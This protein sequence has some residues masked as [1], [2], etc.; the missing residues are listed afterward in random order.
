MTETPREYKKRIDEKWEK[1][2]K[3]KDKLIQ[4][5]DSYEL[6]D[7]KF[8]EKTKQEILDNFVK[9]QKAEQESE[10]YTTIL[11][12][13]WK[14]DQKYV[15]LNIL[16]EELSSTK[17]DI[18]KV[19]K[20]IKESKLD[21]ADETTL[22]IQMAWVRKLKEKLATL[23]S[24]LEELQNEIKNREQE[25]KEIEETYGE[26]LEDSEA[27]PSC[28]E[29]EKS[30]DSQDSTLPAQWETKKNKPTLKNYQETTIKD[31]RKK[32]RT[33]WAI[34]KLLEDWTWIDD[35]LKEKIE[36]EI[37]DRFFE[38]YDE[39][40]WTLRM[41]S[42]RF[43]KNK[44]RES[45][46]K[47]KKADKNNDSE[48]PYIE[49]E[50]VKLGK[51]Y[52]DRALLTKEKEEIR[53]NIEN[54]NVILDSYRKARKHKLWFSGENLAGIIKTAE[55]IPVKIDVDK[56]GSKLIEIKLWNKKYKILDPILDN[57]TSH[58]SSYSHVVEDPN[59]RILP[60]ERR[61]VYL[62]WMEWYNIEWWRNKPL[63]E[64]VKQK[65]AEWFHVA[66]KSD[67]ENLFE[68]FSKIR[69]YSSLTK[70]EKFAMLMY[71]TGLDWTY[72]LREI[73]NW[74]RLGVRF[75]KDNPNFDYFDYDYRLNV[76]MMAISES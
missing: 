22:N 1:N 76:L 73:S 6:L 8:K 57:H 48:L 42:A 37:S 26:I 13:L 44:V 9:N 60:S 45:F 10:Q 74:W 33:R 5:I 31:L 15:E 65:E 16:K 52:W 47:Y 7:E 66:T 69:T 25:I 39:K 17:K 23:K 11:S 27:E 51:I 72:R 36:N 59:Q 18:A 61:Q 28:A 29:S 21:W 53:K 35:D 3:N 56:D 4:K 43:M 30:W 19:E 67:I 40:Q 14:I 55:K 24:K 2:E 38:Y 70:N 63:K 20:E 54:T 32:D 34:F 12:E 62:R 46:K 49:E 75:R 71:L 50:F 41:K 64:Y 68:E 58:D